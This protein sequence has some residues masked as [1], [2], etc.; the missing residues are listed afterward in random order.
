MRHP[1]SFVLLLCVGAFGCSKSDSSSSPKGGQGSSGSAKGGSS[2]SAKNGSSTNGS[3]KGGSGKQGAQNSG[4][5]DSG[6]QNSSGQETG[7]QQDQGGPQATDVVKISAPDQQRAGIHIDQVETRSMPRTLSV[8]GQ[9]QM[10]ETH[11]SHVGVLADGPIIAVNAVEG[12]VVHRGQTL[13]TLHSHTIH[14]TVGALVQA[15]AAAN[16]QGSALAFAQQARDRYT[17]LYSIQA[18]SL[19]ESQRSEQEVQQA[20]NMLADAQANVR[21]ETEHL[22]ELLQVPPSSL[23]PSNLYDRELVPVRAPANGT[24][25]HRNVT[26]GQVVNT[27]FESFTVSNLSTVWISAAVSEHD[28]SLVRTGATAQVTT[29]GYRDQ[30]FPGRVILLGAVLDQTTR[31]IPVRIAVP[32]PGTRLRPGMFVTAQI[33][34]PQTRVAVFIPE[35]AMQDINGVQVVFVTEDGA[36]FRAQAIKVGTRDRGRAEVLDGLKPG[37]HIVTGGAFMVK[38]EMLKGTMGE[39]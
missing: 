35:D 1:I 20:K 32:N 22:S 7:A 23:T 26:V 30:V 38:A 29:E 13:A 39:G 2:S 4:G 36:S 18:A 6:G 14:E 12:A 28:L 3:G 33:A 31:T 15:Y 17:H 8:T 34:E 16:R 19:E 11:T 10:D 37:D 9:V 24:V 25:V 5:Q 21:M 27:G